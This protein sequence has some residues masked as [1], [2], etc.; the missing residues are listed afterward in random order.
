[1]NEPMASPGRGHAVA[2]ADAARPGAFRNEFSWSLSR[3]RV[4]RECA[5]KYYYTHYGMWGGWSPAASPRTREIYILKNL[6]S[7]QM[8]AGTVVRDALRRSIRMLQNG[9]SV[10]STD[11][12][13]RITLARMRADWVSSKRRQNRIDPK[14][15]LGLLEHEYAF[16]VEASVWR[17]LAAQVETCLRNFYASPLFEE[18]QAAL[19]NHHLAAHEARDFMLDA[20]TET[21]RLWLQI[22]CAFRREDGSVVIANWRTGPASAET[23]DQRVQLASQSLYAMHT[24][25]VPLDRIRLIELSLRDGRMICLTASQAD[26]EAA[27]AFIT[28]SIRDMRALLIDPEQ[29]TGR[30]DDFQR[31]SDMRRCLSC[32]YRRLCRK[33]AM[34]LPAPADSAT[35]APVRFRVR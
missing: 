6:K 5:R 8:W 35:L 14:R 1:M 16:P 31:T 11:E 20:G 19:P 22:D 2:S 9:Q 33:P 4:L 3:E 26:I 21:I 34:P 18:L 12:I 10:L 17:A 32:P 25:R 23:D 28:G 24:W 30:E 15:R 29:N 13:V 27:R 7:R